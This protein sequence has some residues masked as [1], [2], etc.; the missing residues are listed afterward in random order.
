MKRI[1]MIS[2]EFSPYKIYGGLGIATKRL[3][4][5]LVNCGNLVTIIFPLNN[6]YFIKS[7]NNLEI[8]PFLMENI[9]YKLSNYEIAKYFSTISEKILIEITKLDIPKES[10]FI[11]HDNE[12]ALTV[13]LIK[14]FR[15]D[16]KIIFW[17]HSLYDYPKRKF[18]NKDH[19]KLFSCESLLASAIDNSDLTVTSS[20][21][22]K[23]SKTVEWP[24]VINEI[25]KSLIKAENDNKILEVESF[26]CLPK[27]QENK[28]NLETKK[29]NKDYFL[30]PSRPS[31]SKGIGFFG[32]LSNN[33]KNDYDF[34]A[35]GPIPKEILDLYPAIQ[36]INW[37]SQRQLFSFM[38]SAKAVILP[39]ITEGYGLSAAESILLSATTIYHDIGGHDILKNYPNSFFPSLTKKEKEKLYLF[40]GELLEEDREP[41]KIWLESKSNFKELLEWW[42]KIIIALPHSDKKNKTIKNNKTWGKLVTEEIKKRGW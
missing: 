5:Q 9:D 38:K 29:R 15:P 3:A 14:N 24:E 25:K 11:V 41:I 32:E 8:K 1:V 39:S 16:C 23:D 27:K 37:L 20:G 7:T 2:N 30:F 42:K 40:W 36:E 4:N 33:Y 21:I 28:K 10:I 13:K 31:F 26:G 22:I 19:K 18:F 35:I 12:M 6:H 34:F 17:L